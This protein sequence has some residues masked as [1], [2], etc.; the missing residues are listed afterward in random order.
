MYWLQARFTI[1]S[2][3]G[4]DAYSHIQLFAI[5]FNE[6]CTLYVGSRR[7]YPILLFTIRGACVSFGNSAVIYAAGRAHRAMLNHNG[8]LSGS[9]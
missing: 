4:Y 3:L 8:S 5:A 1:S 6:V 7:A 9:A 2:A